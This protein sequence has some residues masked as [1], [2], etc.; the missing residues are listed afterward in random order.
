MDQESVTGQVATP[1]NPVAEQRPSDKEVNLRKLAQAK[2]RAELE[3][4]QERAEKAQLLQRLQHLESS[5]SSDID[6]DLDDDGYVE[7]KKLKRTLSKF[8]QKLEQKI[9]RKAEEKARLLLDEERQRSSIYHLKTEYRDFDQVMTEDAVNKFAEKFPAMAST[10]M[11]IPDEYKRKKMAY[12]TIKNLG[13]HEKQ[14]EVT[15]QERVDK[16]QKNLYYTPSGIGTSSSNMGDYSSTGKKAA[17]E[18]MKALSKSA[19]GV[20]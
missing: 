3:R 19:R 20:S 14:K 1:Q 12:E 18:K 6:D 11:E 5:S 13:I 15:A 10:I 8:E 4:D 9:E 16:N 2:E 17:F 7:S